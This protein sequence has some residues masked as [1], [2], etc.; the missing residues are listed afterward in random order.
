MIC[1]V[2]AKPRK[3]TVILLPLFVY[4][5]GKVPCLSPCLFMMPKIKH[6]WGSGPVITWTVL[7]TPA[8]LSLPLILNTT[9][10][11]LGR[12]EHSKKIDYWKCKY[13]VIKLQTLPFKHSDPVRV[14]SWFEDFC[15]VSFLSLEEITRC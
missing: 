13:S 9:E 14:Q 2:C 15:M 3:K 5:H 10:L 4:L 11:C 6:S 7:H 8:F 12:R 1:L